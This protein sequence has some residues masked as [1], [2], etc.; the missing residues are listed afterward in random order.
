[1][2]YIDELYGSMKILYIIMRR[3]FV[4]HSL[5]WVDPSAIGT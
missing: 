4:S 3:R 5:G 2:H 1:M